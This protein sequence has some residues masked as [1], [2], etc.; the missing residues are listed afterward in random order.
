[1][2]SVLFHIGA[3]GFKSV[4][5]R[6]GGSTAFCVAVFKFASGAQEGGRWGGGFTDKDRFKGRNS[7][8]GEEIRFKGNPATGTSGRTAEG[9]ASLEGGACG[10]NILGCGKIKD[11]SWGKIVGVNDFG[12]K[13]LVVGS[14]VF[15][16]GRGN[17]GSKKDVFLRSEGYGVVDGD[18]LIFDAK[19]S[20]F[21]GQKFD[22]G[23][24]ASR[25]NGASES[26]GW[27]MPPALP[28]SDGGLI[29]RKG[30]R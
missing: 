28:W 11:F 12:K 19:A 14:E 2:S 16:D 7:G 18:V 23:G 20:G 15:S 30:W 25:K 6:L 4:V 3:D 8:K 24:D 22:L 26:F 9:P 5:E 27:E 13:A 1:L 17:N 10:K 29:E 21:E